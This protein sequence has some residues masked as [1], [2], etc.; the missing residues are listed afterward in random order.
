MIHILDSR[1]NFTSSFLIFLYRDAAEVAPPPAKPWF[2]R[3]PHLVDVADL[4]LA[5]PLRRRGGGGGTDASLS[6][7]IVAERNGRPVPGAAVRARR[8]DGLIRS[9]AIGTVTDNQGHFCFKAAPAGRYSIAASAVLKHLRPRHGARNVCRPA[10]EFA[11][12][13]ILQ[14]YLR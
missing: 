13:C 6:G 11:L 14:S 7:V 2:D 9:P 4:C 12:R 8:S 5:G 1:V 10:K 3:L